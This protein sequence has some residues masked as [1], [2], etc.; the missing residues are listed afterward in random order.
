MPAT[1]AHRG[2]TVWIDPVERT[3][4]VQVHMPGRPQSHVVA[5]LPQAG[6]WAVTDDREDEPIWFG[7]FEQ[8]LVEALACGSQALQDR[9]L[10]ELRQGVVAATVPLE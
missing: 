2:L 5:V 4:R 1:I 7:D 10:G 8:A 6:G 3:A 9:L